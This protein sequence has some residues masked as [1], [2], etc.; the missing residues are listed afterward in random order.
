M[1]PENK[2][3]DV[4]NL[5]PGRDS[6]R[7]AGARRATI[8]NAGSWRPRPQIKGPP[9]TGRKKWSLDLS[10]LGLKIAKYITRDLF[11]DIQVSG[12]SPRGISTV[13]EILSRPR[14]FSRSKEL[15]QDSRPF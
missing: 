6:R 15:P 9:S 14:A 2:T 11:L 3:Q 7:W 8:P 13:A 1:H 10:Q 12:R 4:H 5:D